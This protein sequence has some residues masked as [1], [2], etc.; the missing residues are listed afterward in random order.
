VLDFI[1]ALKGTSPRV[2]AGDEAWN[3]AWVLGELGDVQAIEPL[4]AALK[5]K[6]WL[7]RCNAAEALEKITV[8]RFGQDAKV[9][10][11]WWK[12]EQKKKK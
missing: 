10:E 9:W 8:E 1:A 5:H 11:K 7:V 12:A 6:I 2:L 3:I 4:I